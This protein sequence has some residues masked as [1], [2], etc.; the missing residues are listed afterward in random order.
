MTSSK[1]DKILNFKSVII[2]DEAMV[3]NQ[4]TINFASGTTSSH[5]IRSE[6]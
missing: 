1:S 3:L 6:G 5:E 4:G 2:G